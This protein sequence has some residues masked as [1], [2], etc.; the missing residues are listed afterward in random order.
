MCVRDRLVPQRLA[1]DARGHVR[2]AG[3]GERDERERERV[4]E[5]ERRRS[6]RRTRAAL[7]AIAL[8]WRRTRADPAAERA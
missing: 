2:R 8:P 3:R 5:A 1:E 7:S 6:R 4:G